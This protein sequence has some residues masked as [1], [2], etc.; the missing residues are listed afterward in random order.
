[1]ELGAMDA[2]GDVPV[3]RYALAP[4]VAKPARAKAAPPPPPIEPVRNP[5]AEALEAAARARDLTSLR[6]ALQDFD[7]CALKRGARNF[8]FTEGLD[9]AD[10]LV[11]G[12]APG[13]L[14]E[15]AGKPFQGAE[16]ALLDRMF[17]A[18]G[19]SRNAD[20]PETA[21]LLATALPWRP[22]GD[23]PASADE[24]SQIAPFLERLIAIAPA[25]AVILMGPSPC[26]ALLGQ[27]ALK[28]L[29]GKWQVIADKP[30]LPMRDP[31]HLLRRPMSKRNAWEDLKA[32]RNKLKEIT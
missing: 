5:R 7:G 20:A 9:A 24:L 10:L 3:D 15:R 17:A 19:R 32:M 30:V 22:P 21:L 29:R 26:Q 8:V 31:R 1:M 25:K 14:E 11:I 13:G 6:A 2:V 4:K 16:G 18:I 12:D 23:R 28:E 27:S